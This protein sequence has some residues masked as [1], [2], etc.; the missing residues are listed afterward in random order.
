M[1]A[2][3]LVVKYLWS[4]IL[5]SGK[6]DLFRSLLLGLKKFNLVLIYFE[7]LSNIMGRCY[8]YN[9]IKVCEVS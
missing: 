6:F 7:V 9:G 3:N 2:G 8:E 5:G 1:K 4:L